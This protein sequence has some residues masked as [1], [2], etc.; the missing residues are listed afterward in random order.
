MKKSMLILQVFVSGLILFFFYQ[1]TPIEDVLQALKSTVPAYLGIA[2]LIMGA[3]HL[4]LALRA[5]MLTDAQ[6]FRITLMRILAI[7]FASQFY[8]LIFPGGMLALVAYPPRFFNETGVF[9]MR[10]ILLLLF[11]AWAVMSFAL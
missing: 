10:A 8:K 11:L 3:N 4:V 7:N 9:W 2:I 5:K 6:G 1:K